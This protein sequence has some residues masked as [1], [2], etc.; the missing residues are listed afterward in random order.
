MKKDDR[1]IMEIL[2]AYDLTGCAHSAAQ[3]VGVDAKTVRRYVAV[4]DAGLD[5][6]EPVERD[7][8]IDPLRDK[9]AEWV[10]DSHGKIRADIAHDRLVA[11]GYDGSERTTRR[12]VAAAKRSWRAGNGRSYK[13]W[14]PEPGRWLQFDSEPVKPAETSFYSFRMSASRVGSL[15]QAVVGSLGAVGGRWRKR[16]GLAA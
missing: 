8:I 4:R 7:S 9:I 5:P 10:A 13:P 15:I 16:A 12:A 14:I 1:E 3:L 2:E 6:Y 11:M